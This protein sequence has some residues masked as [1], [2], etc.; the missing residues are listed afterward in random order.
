MCC[1]CVAAALALAVMTVAASTMGAASTVCMFSAYCCCDMAPERLDLHGSQLE[2]ESL[3]ACVTCD[4][5]QLMQ[6]LLPLPIGC[7]CF[8]WQ[9][10]PT[11]CHVSSTGVSGLQLCQAHDAKVRTRRGQ[12]SLQSLLGHSD[13]VSGLMLLLGVIEGSS[14]SYGPNFNN[15]YH[16]L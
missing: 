7:C 14:S 4:A 11:Q 2:A 3:T 10:R 16:N 12:H 8:T 9:G 1:V 5:V 6:N 15:Y 13:M